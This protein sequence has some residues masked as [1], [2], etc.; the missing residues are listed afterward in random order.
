MKK[1][2]L[3]ALLTFTLAVAGGDKLENMEEV[4]VAPVVAEESSGWEH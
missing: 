3:S 2:L 4:V 1:I